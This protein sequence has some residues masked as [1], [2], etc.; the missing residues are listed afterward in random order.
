MPRHPNTLDTDSDLDFAVVLGDASGAS[1]RISLAAYSAGIM[2]PYGRAGPGAEE[3]VIPFGVLD[4]ACCLAPGAPC[5][6]P[7]D[8]NPRLSDPGWQ[9]EFETVRIRLGDFLNNGS[10][11]DLQNLA[12]IRFEFNEPAGRIA[13][14]D[15]EITSA[16][17]THP[18]PPPCPPVTPCNAMPNCLKGSPL[19]SIDT[20]G[21]GDA[22][23][24]QPTNTF[25]RSPAEVTRVR[26]ARS[27]AAGIVLTWNRA[28]WDDVYSVSRGELSSLG[29][30]S[31]G[32]CLAEGLT[33]RSFEDP[34]PPAAGG[35]FYLVQAQSFECGL[36]TLGFDSFE[37][38]R[39]N[40]DP[41]ACV[42]ATSAEGDP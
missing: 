41:A 25:V 35:S 24:C 6:E 8:C 3:E 4:C 19:S 22:C 40:V 14:D 5:C 34:D 36:G 17:L 26:A 16:K 28:R 38:E 37:L 32:S 23:D 12:A 9:A 29:P 42:G 13:I 1:Q 20:G 2:E 33:V 10:G 30:G 21:A 39:T 7:Q 15:V 18:P 31:Y 27:G 11:I